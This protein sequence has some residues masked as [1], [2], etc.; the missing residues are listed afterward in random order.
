MVERAN[1]DLQHI[2]RDR[3]ISIEQLIAKISYNCTEL[4]LQ[5]S[6]AGILVNATRCCEEFQPVKTMSGLCFQRIAGPNDRQAMVGEYSGFSIYTRL[7]KYDLMSG[8]NLRLPKSLDHTLFHRDLAA[9]S[10]SIPFF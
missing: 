5:C 8:C 10:L 3:H 4:L 1:S 9:F 7:F 6:L 2:L